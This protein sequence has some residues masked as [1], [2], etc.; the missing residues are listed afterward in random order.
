[1]EESPID[2]VGAYIMSKQERE[3]MQE[4]IQNWLI[5]E[6]YKVSK[7]NDPKTYFTIIAEHGTG[8]KIGVSQSLESTD[9]IT[10][11]GTVEFPEDGLHGLAQDERLNLLWDLRFALM[12]SELMF[13]MVPNGQLPNKVHILKNV[14][15]DGLT[16]D[17]FMN[18]AQRV[19]EGKLLTM[20]KFNQK[21]G[22]PEPKENHMIV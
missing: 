10:V 22:A 12:A 5:E 19:V 2:L 7:Q 15:Y 6:G 1:M 14:W 13:V 21:L 3:A 4:K 20:W 9:R 17:R 11:S 8:M 16:K 18:V